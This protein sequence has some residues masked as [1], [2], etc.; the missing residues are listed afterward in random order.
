MLVRPAEER[1]HFVA[2]CLRRDVRVRVES[3][4]SAE[5]GEADV[6]EDVL[7]DQR[8]PEQEDR[9]R[10]HDRDPQRAQ[11]DRPCAHEDGH[12]ARAH[13]QRQ[14]LKAARP[15]RAQVQVSERPRQPRWPTAAARR[16]VLCRRGRG[17][18]GGQEDGRD[19][20]D[21]PELPERALQQ[22][23]TARRRR[24]R[25]RA[26]ARGS[27]DLDRRAG[28]GRGALHRLIVA[29]APGTCG[30][31]ASPRARCGVNLG[32]G[33]RAP[34]NVESIPRACNACGGQR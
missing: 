16:H 3:V 14:R 30:R 29:F 32:L 13:H 26:R 5:S 34:G 6:A 23:A 1:E 9:V 12:V 31:C 20:P 28:G 15:E 19:H 7:G 21:Q 25:A 10:K 17:V 2:R 33:R 4:Q 22:C 11:R 27:S 24:V 18:G 8:R